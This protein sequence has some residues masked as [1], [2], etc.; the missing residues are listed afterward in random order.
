MLGIDDPLIWSA[1]LLCL[2]S[3][4]LCV[5]Y[6]AVNWNKGDEPVQPEDIEWAK[7]EKTEV[8]DVL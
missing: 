7:E 4:L 3:T 5:V 1:Y 8:E 6:G 2:L